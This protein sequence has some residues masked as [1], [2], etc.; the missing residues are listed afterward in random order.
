MTTLSQQSPSIF[1]ILMNDANVKE[2]FKW[3]ASQKLSPEHIWPE[4]RTIFI[5]FRVGPTCCSIQTLYDGNKAG[6][7]ILC[8]VNNELVLQ[9]T[10]LFEKQIFFQYLKEYFLTP[11][12]YEQWM[13]QLEKD[14][15][16]SKRLKQLHDSGTCAG[17]D[18]C[19]Y[20]IRDVVR[21]YNDEA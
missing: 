1:D 4:F 9:K 17:R 13:E 6:F 7:L 5:V 15:K 3:I 20:C 12:E 19:R 11:A 8:H 2:I 14:I 16:K 18:R 21:G 10:H